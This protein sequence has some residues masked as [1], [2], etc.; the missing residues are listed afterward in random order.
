[1]LV[2]QGEV[3]IKQFLDMEWNLN[4]LTVRPEQPEDTDES[5]PT[6]PE[7]PVFIRDQID[8]VSVQEEEPQPPISLGLKVQLGQSPPSVI[9]TEQ[10]PPPGEEE[11]DRRG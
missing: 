6:V 5:S 7:N 1:M 9:I 8:I 10:Q 11:G 4:Q 3:S 2:I